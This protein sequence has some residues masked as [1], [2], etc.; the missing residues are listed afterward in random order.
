MSRRVLVAGASDL[1]G[2]TGIQG[3]VRII[4]GLGGEARAVL[5]CVPNRDPAL[6]GGLAPVENRRL[7]QHMR[8]ALAGGTDAVKIGLLPDTA[9]IDGVVDLLEECAGARPVVVDAAITDE[10]G[11][12][13][14]D[15][16]TLAH[17]KRRVLCLATVLVA[18]VEAAGILAGIAVTGPDGKRLAAG[19][20]RTMGPGTV[21]VKDEHGPNGMAID[22]IAWNDD[23]DGDGVLDYPRPGVSDPGG[24]D[25]AMAAAVATG[26]AQGM[27]V[28]TAVRRARAFVGETGRFVPSARGAL[29]A[30]LR[31]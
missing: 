2:R 9:T 15:G 7:R 1:T 24:F 11:C 4:N 13:I 14:V 16:D 31:G 12:C 17:L 21:V 8:T 29:P 10:R 30:Q 25:G 6:P 5:T 27:P 18:S 28:F 19:I 22:F 3:D 23:E 20:L 26:L